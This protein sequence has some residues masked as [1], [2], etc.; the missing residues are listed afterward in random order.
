MGSNVRF[1]CSYGVRNCYWRSCWC[2]SIIGNSQ[3]VA[4]WRIDRQLL[5][6]AQAVLAY[7]VDECWHCLGAWHHVFEIWEGYCLW[8][9]LG[10]TA[11]LLGVRFVDY[12]VI[13][14]V[15][16]RLRLCKHSTISNHGKLC[17]DVTIGSLPF[18]PHVG[19]HCC[20]RFIEYVTTIWP[21]PACW[22]GI[23]SWSCYCTVLKIIT[24]V[25]RA[26]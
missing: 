12:L 16:H 17:S 4:P 6:T 13:I 7:G 19:L 14:I 23:L 18:E 21:N 10:R 20:L 11:G 5:K 26:N 2:W 22:M 3:E 9:N 15:N 8:L 24:A 1:I 25:S